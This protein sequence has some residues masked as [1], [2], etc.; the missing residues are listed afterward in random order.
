MWQLEGIEKYK[1]KIRYWVYFSLDRQI[2]LSKAELSSG[3][4]L[5]K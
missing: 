2:L 3:E 4:K 5:K 1:T